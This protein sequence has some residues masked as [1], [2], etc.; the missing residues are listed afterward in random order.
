MP[1]ELLRRL[2][3]APLICDGAMGTMLYNKGV[4]INRCYD[5]INLT[6]PE[7]VAE[8]HRDYVQAGAEV[9]ETNTFG[10]NPVQLE[11]HGLEAETEEIN[12]RAA[13]I[14]V[15]AS[16]AG[17]FVLGAI[18]PLGIR[19][20]PWGPTGVDDARAF[21]RRLMRLHLTPRD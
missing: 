19:I 16:G 11:R 2:L 14:A 1:K 18:G 8:V 20:E 17:V 6:Q 3:E 12:R 10:A 5:E 13:E 4:F 21:F 9:I 7:L 15:E